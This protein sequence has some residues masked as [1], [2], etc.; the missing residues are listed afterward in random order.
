MSR[1]PS[2]AEFPDSITTRGAKHLNSLIDAASEG[3]DSYILYVIQREDCNKFT[4]ARDIDPQY[5]KLLTYAV[6]KNVK[7]LCYDCKFSTKRIKL[8]KF[9]KLKIDD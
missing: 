2:L 6:K 8:N 1:K 9:I 5:Y 7:I 4:I 3:Y